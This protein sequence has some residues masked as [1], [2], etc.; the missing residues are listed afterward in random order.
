MGK[1][2]FLRMTTLCLPCKETRCVEVFSKRETSPCRFSLFT[3]RSYLQPIRQTWEKQFNSGYHEPKLFM[4]HSVTLN[5]QAVWQCSNFIYV[6]G[7]QIC[8]KLVLKDNAG[9]CKI[10]KEKVDELGIPLE[11][12]L[13]VS[14][15]SPYTCLLSCCAGRQMQCNVNKLV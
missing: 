15:G 6:K 7:S 2:C 12:L 14:V 13:L 9:F 8:A 4:N 5:W 1:V 10:L 3:M 11:H